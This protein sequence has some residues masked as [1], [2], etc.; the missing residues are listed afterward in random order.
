MRF[1][2]MTAWKNS[3]RRFLSGRNK[4]LCSPIFARGVGLYDAIHLQQEERESNGNHCSLSMQRKYI[5]ASANNA[6]QK[7][8]YVSR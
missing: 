8:P 6:L 7:T 5:Y 2:N 3:N 1:A 4:G